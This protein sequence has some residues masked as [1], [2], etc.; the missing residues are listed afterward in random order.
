MNNKKRSM[1]SGGFGFVLAAAGS[2]GAEEDGAQ[3]DGGTCRTGGAG[4]TSG[5]GGYYSGSDGA[6]TF[7]T[8]DHSYHAA[9]GLQG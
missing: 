3:P 5:N 2:G 9:C 7:G 1:F 4:R 6:S 8:C